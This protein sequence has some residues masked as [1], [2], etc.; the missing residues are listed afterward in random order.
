[1]QAGLLTAYRD[2]L[3]QGQLKADPQQERVLGRLQ[4]LADALK[5]AAPPARGGL[6]ARLGIGRRPAAAAP[7][8]IYIHGPVGRG[9]SMLMDL[10]FDAAPVRLKRRV[11]FHEFMLEVHERLHRRRRALVD[12]GAPPE[13]DPLPPFA[14]ELAGEARLLC[15]DE[16]QVTNIAD[17]MILGRLFGTLFDEGVTVVATSNRPPD[18]LYRN[19]LQRERFLPFI[20]LLKERLE[21]LELA[22]EQDYRLARLRDMTVYLSPLVP[23]TAEK[24]EAAFASLTDGAGG[25]RRVLRTQG[26]AVTVNRAAGGIAWFTFEELCAR[27]LGAADY[28]AIAEHFHTV[29][30]AGIPRLSPDK[31]DQAAR[32]VTLIDALYEHRVKLVCAAAAQPGELY[33][34]GDGA[35]EF[36]RTVSRLME[37]QSRDYLERAHED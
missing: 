21:V 16:F 22:G 29:F 34:A 18:D 28:I 13:A 33:P 7:A 15:F 25:E 5:A 8:G 26:R 23:A 9:K 36:E 3:S 30:I 37:M 11:H 12:K 35:F 20:A 24:L 31:R 19:G 1:M 14:R 6:L 27:P 2:R 17:A 32:F 10:F 4:L